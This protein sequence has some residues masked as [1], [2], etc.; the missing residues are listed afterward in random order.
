[1]HP[2]AIRRAQAVEQMTDRCSDPDGIL[3]FGIDSPHRIRRRVLGS[4][5][6]VTDTDEGPSDVT[7]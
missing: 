2:V 1:M 4:R 5:Y 3:S 7:A 6:T